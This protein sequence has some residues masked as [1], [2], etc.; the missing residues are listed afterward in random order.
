MGREGKPPTA[1]LSSGGKKGWALYLSRR[2][3]QDANDSR[4]YLRLPSASL[5]YHQS[6]R[7]RE[8][9]REEGP[10]NR[11][12]PRP[13]G[14]PERLAAP[15][16]LSEPRGK[17]SGEETERQVTLHKGRRVAGRGVGG[18]RGEWRLSLFAFAVQAF[19]IY[20]YIYTKSVLYIYIYQY[21]YQGFVLKG[22]EEVGEKNL[23]RK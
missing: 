16:N 10:A 5:Y 7:R 21:I 14:R 19:Y 12:P 20:V 22:V 6:S 13:A 1:R 18:G 11:G 15:R 17:E 3:S 4:L 23:G 9:F 2:C 8:S